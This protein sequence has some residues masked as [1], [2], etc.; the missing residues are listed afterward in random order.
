M[1]KEF[2]LQFNALNSMKKKMSSTM[3]FNKQLTD[4]KMFEEEY[5]K[6]MEGSE[7]KLKKIEAGTKICKGDSSDLS[8]HLKKEPLM[9]AKMQSAK[10]EPVSHWREM[11]AEEELIILILANRFF[12]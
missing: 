4:T 8:V 3:K 6:V 7:K 11:N 9:L 1:S 10:N 5:N 2:S 12:L